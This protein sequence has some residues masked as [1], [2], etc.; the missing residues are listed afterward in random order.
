MKIPLIKKVRATYESSFFLL[1]IERTMESLRGL[2]I[3]VEGNIAVGKTTLLKTLEKEA[4]KQEISVIIIEEEIDT[5]LLEKF[6]ADPK[7]YSREF[8]DTMMRMRISNMVRAKDLSTL[9]NV[10]FLDTGLMREIAFSRANLDSGHMTQREYDE[11]MRL[12][13]KELKDKNC[14]MPDLIIVLDY[15][16]DKCIENIKKRNRLN[17]I[18]LKRAYL[19]DIREC[20]LSAQKH[21]IFLGYDG[22]ITI[23]VTT[24]YPEMRDVLKSIELLYLHTSI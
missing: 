16:V 9:E 21:P 15:P 13:S 22:F 18:M 17:E 1:F 6:N 19:E 24:D 14:S 3:C 7:K 2:V 23:Y 12:F 4:E 5:V 11:H 20:H 10:V 8:Q